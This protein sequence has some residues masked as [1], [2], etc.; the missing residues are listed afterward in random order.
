MPGRHRG[1]VLIFSGYSNFQENIFP[2][3]LKKQT[4]NPSFITLSTLKIFFFKADQVISDSVF[5]SV[6]VTPSGGTNN[7][8]N[9]KKLYKCQLL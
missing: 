8:F 1:E 4:L 3:L 5:Y 2:H 6:Q 7:L 9:Y